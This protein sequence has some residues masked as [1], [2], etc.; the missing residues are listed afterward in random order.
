MSLR[1]FF[2]SLCLGQDFYHYHSKVTLTNNQIKALPTTPQTIIAAPGAGFRIAGFRV[3][4]QTRSSAGAYTNVN[5]NAYMSLAYSGSPS[6]NASNYVANDTANYLTFLDE[7]M[8]NA[9]HAFVLQSYTY[10]LETASWGNLVA[11][12][13]FNDNEPLQLVFENNG[14][15]D[16]TGGNAANTWVFRASYDIEPA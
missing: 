10:A 12:E 13:V 6:A 15:G 14:A 1:A 5:P 4:V 9:N 16:L 2:T 11:P 7:V 8:G 3:S